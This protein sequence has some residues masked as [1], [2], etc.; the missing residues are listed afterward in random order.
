[1]MTMKQMKRRLQG[2]SWEERRQLSKKSGV[3]FWTIHSVTMK[4]RTQNPR[5][6]TFLALEKALR[7]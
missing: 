2:M 6:D 3:P 7:R 5:L 4:N 1:M